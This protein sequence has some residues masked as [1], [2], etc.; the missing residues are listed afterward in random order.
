[1]RSVLARSW[2]AIAEAHWADL[3][4][5]ADKM[6]APQFPPGAGER[7]SSCSPAILGGLRTWH[8]SWMTVVQYMQPP[9]IANS[10]KLRLF[11]VIVTLKLLTMALYVSKLNPGL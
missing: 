4:R 2:T 10:C 8:R 1:M 3:S 6:F 9:H 5:E 11:K 7:H